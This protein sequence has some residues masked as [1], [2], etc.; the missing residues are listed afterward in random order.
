M[1]D[2]SYHVLFKPLVFPLPA[3]TGKRIILEGV[4]AM[5]QLPFGPGL[6]DIMGHMVPASALAFEANGL[7]FASRVVLGAGLC[8]SAG[9]LRAFERFGFGMLEVGPIT[10]NAVEQ[11]EDLLRDLKGLAIIGNGMPVNK[12]LDFAVRKILAYKPKTPVM[13]RVCHAPGCSPQTA[14]QELDVFNAKLPQWISGI[15]IDTRWCL[16]DWTHDQLEQYLKQAASY[17]RK[18]ALTI[19]P[20]I[21]AERLQRTVAILA[22]S[23][24]Q[25]LLI[26]GGIENSNNQRQRSYGRP[27]FEQTVKLVTHVRQKLP[28]HFIV[29]GGGV[30]E[31]ADGITM[32]EAGAD[33]V[34]VYS[35]LVYSGP[36]LPKRIN[37]LSTARWHFAEQHA[38]TAPYAMSSILSNGWLGFALIGAGLIITG[39][40]AITVALTTVVLPYDEK[41]LGVTRDALITLNANLLPFMS[42]DRVTYAGA[43][44]SCGI[45]FFVLSAFGAR[46]GQHW[47]Y[48]AAMLANAAGFASF[49]LF[50]GFHY[51][52][53]LHALA[54]LILIPFFIWGLLRPP[55]MQAMRAS[56]ERNTTAWYHSLWGQFWF[57][58]IGAG[59]ILAGL[60]ICKVGT[61]TV[62]VP[63][64]L[65]FMKTTADQLLCHNSHLLPTIAHDRAG[66]GGALVTA[67]IG[68][69]LSALHGYRQGEGW[70]W[71]MF[72]IG[73]LPGFLSTLGIHFA[74]GYT[75]FIHLLPA[76]IAACMFVAGLWLSYKYLCVEPGVEQMLAAN[77]PQSK[78]GA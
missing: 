5:G 41:F 32:L 66:F 36:G 23:D 28:Q 10:V 15:S 34:S 45:L 60:T 22:S 51:L 33:M 73:G 78:T 37:E 63:E 9:H 25:T 44:M 72:L 48:Q 1:P 57:V 54:T 4:A 39:S 71:W 75:S 74:I 11:Q 7:K 8:D 62:F 58:C 30:I 61:S 31:P 49:L 69:L 38:K 17:G 67:G 68:V 76:Y 20:D 52:D 50:L 24:I 59:L 55:R 53:P 65:M 56:N 27:T 43:G 12:G 6:I 46:S 21:S 18:I 47:A 16:F 40:S 77:A 70:L 64:D 14:M 13:V 29:A 3:A 2:W 19:T 35:G 42:H 26:S